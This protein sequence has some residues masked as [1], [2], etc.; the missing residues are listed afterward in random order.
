MRPSEC[1]D[2][3]FVEHGFAIGKR[4]PEGARI[5]AVVGIK[6]FGQ[7]CDLEMEATVIEGFVMLC[8]SS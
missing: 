2:G 4:F 3:V 1:G 5:W 8:G 7:E 6:E